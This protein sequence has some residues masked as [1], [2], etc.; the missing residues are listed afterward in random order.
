MCAHLATACSF[1]DDIT[2]KIKNFQGKVVNLYNGWTISPQQ[3]YPAHASERL[4]SVGNEYKALQRTVN[5]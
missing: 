4:A 1:Q 2:Y 3:C 5:E